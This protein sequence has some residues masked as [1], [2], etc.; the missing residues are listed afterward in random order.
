MTSARILALT[1]G[2]LLSATLATSA[3]AVD[4]KPKAF[5]LTVLGV[6]VDV[7]VTI[8]FDANTEG[9]ALALRVRAKQV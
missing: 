6:K 1:A 9:D 5:P 7:P 2:T 3:P 4:L 8:S